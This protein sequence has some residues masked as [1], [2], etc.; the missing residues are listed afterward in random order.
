VADSASNDRSVSALDLP[1]LVVDRT[2]AQPGGSLTGVPLQYTVTASAP[3]QPTARL[4]K[5]LVLPAS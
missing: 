4:T 5:A 2:D 1:G 3:D